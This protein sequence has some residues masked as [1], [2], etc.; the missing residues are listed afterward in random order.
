MCGTTCNALK[1]EGIAATLI[2]AADHGFSD[3]EPWLRALVDGLYVRQNGGWDF[4]CWAHVLRLN[5][6]LYRSGILYWLNDQRHRSGE[7]G[8]VPCR[9]A[10]REGGAMRRHGAH[11]KP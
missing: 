3:D 8:G 2:V 5:R 10:A 9:A 4:A 7:P 11:R 6:Q 1:Q